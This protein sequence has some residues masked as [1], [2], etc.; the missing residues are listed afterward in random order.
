MDKYHKIYNDFLYIEDEFFNLIYIPLMNKQHKVTGYAVSNLSL[1]NKILEFSYHQEIHPGKTEKR[2]AR[3]NLGTSMHEIVIG[4]KAKEGYVIDHID[5]D[6]LLNTE[7]NLRYATDGLNAQ[8]KTKQPNTISEYIGVGYHEE[9]TN[10]K[11]T[12]TMSYNKKILYLGS[13][14]D[15]IEAAKD[16]DI[17]V[18]YYYKGESPKTNNL[19]TKNEIEDVRNNGIPEKYHRKTRDLPKNIYITKDNTYKVKITHK[20]KKYD[21]TVKTLEAAILLKTQFLEQIGKNKEIAKYAKEIT[22]NIDGLAIIYMNNGME[23]LVD[24]DHWYDLNQYKWL[25]RKNKDDKMYGYPSTKIDGIGMKSLHIYV[26]EKY[27]GLIPSNMTVDHVIST[28]IL[29]VRLKNLRLANSSLQNHN[30]EMPKN[31]ID[32]YKGI[33]FTTSGYHVTINRCYYGVY[34]TAEEAAH[35]ANEVYTIIYGDQ[36]T[37]NVIDDSRKTTKYNRISD[38]NITE[39]YAM[40]LTK[41]RDVKNIVIIKNLNTTRDKKTNNGKIMID[42]INLKTL[43]KYK[44]I[45]VNKLYP[46]TDV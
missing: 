36:A 46:L 33:N 21:K 6:G 30:R 43:D 32:E 28:N 11:W 16:Y 18:I 13:F 3:S 35:K 8:N 45:I 40:S 24:S 14:K 2:Y 44:Q 1:K 39:E 5:S 19:L 37:L 26:Y 27:V 17:H 31:G 25:C 7:E 12:S 38:E 42:A 15:E 20:D 34:K 23:C 4:G 22:R 29:D 9:N 41:V 10:N